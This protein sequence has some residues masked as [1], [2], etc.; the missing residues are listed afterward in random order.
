[1]S[2]PISG[3]GHE[4]E[5]LNNLPYSVSYMK[6]IY[7]ISIIFAI[8]LIAGCTASGNAPEAFIRANLPSSWNIQV[9]ENTV[10]H[11]DLYI[12]N[13]SA[14]CKLISIKSSEEFEKTSTTMNCPIA[15]SP[16]DTCGTPYLT[17]Y[18]PEQRYWFCPKDWDGEVLASKG[19]IDNGV[20]CDNGNYKIIIYSSNDVNSSIQNLHEIVKQEFCK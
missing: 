19:P 20:L 9:A 6:S 7:P 18:N 2:S 4:N 13:G 17:N 1:M 12:Y 8:I 11:P 5:R 14:T 3:L 15:M 16:N 10:P